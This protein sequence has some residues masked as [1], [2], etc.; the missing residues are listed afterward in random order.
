MTKTAKAT[1]KAFIVG[2]DIGYSNV[3]LAYGY[4]GDNDPN[5]LVRPAHAA[6]LNDVKGDRSA[7]SGEYFVSVN[8]TT[9]LS[10]IAPSRSDIK[11]ELHANYPATDAYYALFL[12]AL[13]AAT[14]D[15]QV[16]VDKLVTGLPTQQSREPA[17]VGALVER[18]KGKHQVSPKVS[19]EV[20][21]VVVVPQ[22]AGI[23]SDIY[24]TF[25]DVE[26]LDESNLLVLDPGFYSVDWVVYNMGHLNKDASGTALEAMSAVLTEINKLIGIQYSASPGTDKIEM[27]FQSGKDSV[28][29]NGNRVALAPFIEQAKLNVATEALKSTAT[30]MRFQNESS[31]DF[32]LLGGGGGDTYKDAVSELF[33]AAK[34][35]ESADKVVSNAVGFWLIGLN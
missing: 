10:M 23:L 29:V 34:I 6:P 4:E 28:V 13:A 20:R 2:L 5:T 18:L 8:D 12:G 11:R 19:I 25:E 35:I 17:L 15:G 32:V 27:A 22:P 16:V 14:Q 26:L 24:S 33:P 7:L 1:G 30:A 3:K 31:L 21:E 9:W